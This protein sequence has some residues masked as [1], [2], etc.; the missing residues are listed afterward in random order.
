LIDDEQT[1]NIGNITIKGILTEGHTFGSMCYQINGKYLFTGDALGLK[2][3]KIVG[4][5]DFFNVDTKTARKSMDKIVNL[6]D[7][8]FLFS[9]HYGYSDDYKSAVKDWTNK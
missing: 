9:A 7:V 4:F 6:P 2:D 5:N 1:F 3:G 8:E